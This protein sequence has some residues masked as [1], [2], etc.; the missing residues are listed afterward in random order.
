M[1]KIKVRRTN[2]EELP[3]LSVLRDSVAAELAA[4]PSHNGVL[5]LD[6]ELDPDL[7][8]L[9]THDPD[10]FLT[11]EDKQETVGFAVGHVRSRQC[12]ISEMW[13]LPQHRGRGAGDLLMQRM[14]AY[15]ER[16]GAREFLTV[17]PT[18]GIAQSLLLRNGFRPLA[19]VYQLTIPPTVAPRLGHALSRLMDGRDVTSD[20]YNR[21]GQADLDRIDQLNRNIVRKADHDYWLKERRHHAAFIRQG[22]RIAAYAYGGSDQVGPVAGTTREA[23]LAAL[24]WAIKL[25]SEASEEESVLTVRI[26]APFGEAVDAVLEAGCRFEATLMLYGRDLS[27]AFDRSIL[28]HLALP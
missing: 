20:L 11:A 19:P 1:A 15:G 2:R 22:Q 7:T 10:G 16:S 14:L 9:I 6:M 23:A 12:I 8:H 17:V 27:L 18:E 3:G 26:P 5:D 4:F 25:A 13:V 28:G 24:G 21:R